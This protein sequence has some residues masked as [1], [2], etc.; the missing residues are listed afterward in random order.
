MRYRFFSI[1]VQDP[2]AA[3]DALNRFLAAHRIVSVD[4]ELVADGRHSLWCLCV[5]Y[6]DGEGA[7]SAQPKGKVDYREILSEAD[8]AVYAKLRALRK[9]LAERDG[10]PAYSVFTNEQLA[11]MVRQ[12]TASPADLERLAG[13][14]KA[15]SEKF[16]AAFLAL[17]REA[18]SDRTAEQAGGKDATDAH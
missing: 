1:P 10:V 12:R 11:E 15:R 17:L 5:S 9:Q 6:L 18:G 3:E 8:F 13:V 16:G 4:R 2:A 7:A 14:G